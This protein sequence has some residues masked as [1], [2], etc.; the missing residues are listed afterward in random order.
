[1]QP[2]SAASS[3]AQQRRQLG[4]DEDEAYSK[5]AAWAQHF[6]GKLSAAQAARQKS[7]AGLRAMAQV[8]TCITLSRDTCERPAPR[9]HNTRIMLARLHS[10]QP[11]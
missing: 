8:G 11:S 3:S 9:L 2:G 4:S 6:G 7:V 10:F 5:V 1:M